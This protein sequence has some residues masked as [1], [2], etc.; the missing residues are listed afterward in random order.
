M[1]DFIHNNKDRYGVN[2]I[3]RILPIA[4]STSYRMLDLI[5]NPEHQAKR[6]LHGLH[7]AKQIKRIWKDSSGRY[8]A[9]K[10][11]QQLKREDYVIAS[12]DAKARYTRCL[13]R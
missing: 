13:A 5:V 9:R 2:V 7:H 8:G 10:V 1:M 12:I 11:W 3:C 4:A 6:D